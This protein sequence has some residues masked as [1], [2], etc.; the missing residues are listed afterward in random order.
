MLTSGFLEGVCR[1]T[2]QLIDGTGEL[3]LQYVLFTKQP[4]KAFMQ[5]YASRGVSSRQASRVR[6]R[7]AVH[8]RTG[9]PP[10]L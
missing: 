7:L 4:K 6:L 9:A 5:M 10:A 2:G 3:S 8:A 1:G